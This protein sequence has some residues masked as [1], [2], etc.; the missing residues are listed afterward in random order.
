MSPE[1]AEVIELLSRAKAE[2]D[3]LY[4]LFTRTARGKPVPPEVS[5]RVAELREKL[6][7]IRREQA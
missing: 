1:E 4:W 2:E 7:T 3:R 5:R 6:L